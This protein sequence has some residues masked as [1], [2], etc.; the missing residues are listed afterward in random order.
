MEK[1]QK[2]LL[3]SI[4]QDIEVALDNQIEITF[5]FHLYFH[6]FHVYRDV[7]SPLVDGK[8]LECSYEKKNM[9]NEFAIAVCG[10]DLSWRF[11]VGNVPIRI[12]KLFLQQPNSFLSYKVTEKWVNRRTD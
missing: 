12:S 9:T 7:W 2:P 10:N 4:D 6:G 3:E 8:G 1:N 5:S 11:I